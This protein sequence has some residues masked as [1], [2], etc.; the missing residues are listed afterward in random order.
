VV[1]VAVAWVVTG[2]AGYALK[3][4]L[5]GDHFEE[6]VRDVFLAWSGEL[7]FFTIVGAAVAIISI[8][9][10]E[11]PTHRKLRDRV[12]VLFGE[13][14]V[15]DG[16]LS[17]SATM[18]QDYFAQYTQSFRRTLVI[19]AYNKQKKA[20]LIHTRIDT[21]ITNLLEDVPITT[22]YSYNVQV[23]SGLD[24][25]V[26][27][28]RLLSIKI[29]GDELLARPMLVLDAFDTRNQV[30]IPPAGLL[31]ITIESEMWHSEKEWHSHHT[32]R[33]VS[34]YVVQCLNLLDFSPEI[35]VR[36]RQVRNLTDD[37]ERTALSPLY[38]KPLVLTEGHDVPPE[39]QIVAYMIRPPPSSAVEVGNQSRTET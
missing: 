13:A 23:D 5:F 15:P 10:A 3:E 6:T 7:A 8:E 21:D 33:Y 26:P 38:N 17:Y 20:F 14:E 32:V 24:S 27:A 39:E 25:L 35:V 11:D 4:K 19:R 1:S 9:K 37:K 28:N 2:A 34:H 12:R 31:P 29:G 22:N 18:F 36:D 16:L 30:V